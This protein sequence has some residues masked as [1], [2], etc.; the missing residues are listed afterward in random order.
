MAADHQAV[1]VQGALEITGAADGDVAVAL[2]GALDGAVDM[3]LAVEGQ[4]PEES[5]PLSD[6]RGPRLL[7]RLFTAFAK[8]S[9]LTPSSC[10]KSAS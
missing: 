3:Q 10:S 2:D 9:H 1:G 8:E 6:N 5:G 7:T 4:F